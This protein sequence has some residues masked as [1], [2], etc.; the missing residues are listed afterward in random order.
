MKKV[1]EP[2]IGRLSVYLRLLA[3]LA[4]SGKRTVSSEELARQSG[5]T[6]AQVRK[7]LS[8]FGT[9]GK[10]GLGYSVPEL[11]ERLRSILGL[12]RSWGVALVGAG[13]IGAAL[14]GYENFRRQ[15]FHIQ[16]VFD[17]DPA[18]VGQ[19]WNGLV[20]QADEDMDAVLSDLGI[21]IAVVAVPARAAQQVVD[22]L[23]ALGV[24]GI[25]NFAPVQLEVPPE[26][27]VRTVDMAMEMEGLSYALSREEPRSGAA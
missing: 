13:K 19:E 26:V 7:D 12:E 1:S 3:E 18:K 6:A 9:F 10:R 17:S 16:A 8:L 4:D 11:V 15:G 27:V 22:R 25:L 5:T 14:F 20:V 24:R 2:T 23:V 21:E